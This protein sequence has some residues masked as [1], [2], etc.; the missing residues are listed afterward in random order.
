MKQLRMSG[1]GI[2][3]MELD[4]STNQEDH[5]AGVLDLGQR[6]GETVIDPEQNEALEK[7]RPGEAVFRAIFGSDS[8]DD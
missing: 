3:P 8:E 2:R 1:G 6:I 7:E 4:T 5:E